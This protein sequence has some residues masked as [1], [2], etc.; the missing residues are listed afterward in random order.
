MG[1]AWALTLW[2]HPYAIPFWART[3]VTICPN[4]KIFPLYSAMALHWHPCAQKVDPTLCTVWSSRHM[5]SGSDISVVRL[6]ETN[7][8]ALG[9]GPCIEVFSPSINSTRL[10]H[11]SPL[12]S[13][14]P[15][16]HSPLLSTSSLALHS[17]SKPTRS[18]AN[19][20]GL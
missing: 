18:P 13:L 6:V 2:Q 12:C 10:L 4:F 8:K 14:L 1:G 19:L 9:E 20:L 7:A 15:T 11:F 3:Q 16:F 5:W 17:S